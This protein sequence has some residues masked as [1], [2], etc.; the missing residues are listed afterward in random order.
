[1]A[2]RGRERR[3]STS[4]L[5]PKPSPVFFSDEIIS[6][7]ISNLNFRDTFLCPFGADFL[8][9]GYFRRVARIVLSELK[10]KTKPYMR[11]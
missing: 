8:M 6:K 9:Q 5:V 3:G 1:M 11:N 2:R 7:S 4:R 10:V